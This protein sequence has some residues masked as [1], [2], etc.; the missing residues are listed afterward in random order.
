MID[1]GVEGSQRADLVGL[2]AG[3]AGDFLLLI[4]LGH[5]LGF[6]FGSMRGWSGLRRVSNVMDLGRLSYG[7]EIGVINLGKWSNVFIWENWI[8]IKREAIFRLRITIFYIVATCV[9]H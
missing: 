5:A 3:N 7:F 9:I 1:G 8:F 4:F 2:G 6:W